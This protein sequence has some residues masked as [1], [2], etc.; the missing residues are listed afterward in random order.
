MAVLSVLAKVTFLRIALIQI[1]PLW[2][3]AEPAPQGTGLGREKAVIALDRDL[4]R[5]GFPAPVASVVYVSPA[6]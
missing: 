3:A 1:D 4:C 5:G 2:M 6:R